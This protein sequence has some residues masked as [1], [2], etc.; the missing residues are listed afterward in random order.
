MEP[1][2]A[3]AR[4]ELFA[5]FAGKLP[6]GRIGTAE[7][8]AH[9]VLFAATNGYLTGTVIECTGGGHLATG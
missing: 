9:A 2:A 3:D 7:D 6:V 1:T 4:R 5:E 8:I